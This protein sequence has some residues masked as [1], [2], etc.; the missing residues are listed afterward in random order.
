MWGEWGETLGWRWGDTRNEGLC[1]CVCVKIKKNTRLTQLVECMT[2]NHMVE[3]SS[4]SSSIN[5]YNVV[6]RMIVL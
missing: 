2:F 6:V 4:P 1:V 5:S 3:G